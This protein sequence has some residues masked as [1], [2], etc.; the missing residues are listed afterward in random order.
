MDIRAA[1]AAEQMMYVDHAR[2]FRVVKELGADGIT[3]ETRKEAWS[4]KCRLCSVKST[5]GEMAI[6]SSTYI[7]HV[8]PGADVCG[9]DTVEIIRGLGDTVSGNVANARR[10]MTHNE[11]DIVEVKSM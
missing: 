2:V 8:P 6:A 4:G 1:I 5:M 3:R 11:A 9:G 7:L 10:Y